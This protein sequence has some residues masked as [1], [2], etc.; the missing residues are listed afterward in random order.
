[1]IVMGPYLELPYIVEPK[2][3]GPMG[4][5]LK[6][7]AKPGV[8][9]TLHMIRITNYSYK[10][11]WELYV[12]GDVTEIDLPDFDKLGAFN[13]LPGGKLR[14]RLWRIYAPGLDI[15]H[16]NHK[17]LS[18]WKW[19]SYAYNWVMTS[20]FKDI[21]GTGLPTPGVPGGA[22]PGKIPAP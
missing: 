7:T 6:W 4:K 22:E 12:K 11:L 21:S 8:T 15:D 5:K 14:I 17:Q 13:P 3:N 1:M 9:P 19:V 2:I 16:Y 20:Q 18:V 10:T